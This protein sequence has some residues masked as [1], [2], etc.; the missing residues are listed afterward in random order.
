MS[1][2][3]IEMHNAQRGWDASQE[4]LRGDPERRVGLID[5]GWHEGTLH[6]AGALALVRFGS[7]YADPASADY[8]VGDVLRLSGGAREAFVYVY[9]AADVPYDLS[10]SRAAFIRLDRLTRS[11]AQFVVE[12]CG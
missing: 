2:H 11:A 8:L 10:L 1:S 5:V 12:V 3:V 6:P 7:D 9:G 4:L